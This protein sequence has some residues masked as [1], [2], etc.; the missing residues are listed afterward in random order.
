MAL[1]AAALC[2]LVL[3]PIG[4]LVVFAFTDRAR[5]FTLANFRTLFTDPAFV[6]PLLTT[7]TIATSVSL[8]CCLVAAPMGWIV[9]R[10]DMPLAAPSASW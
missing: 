7:L 3:L 4:W 8:I 9:A 10:T 1:L 2:L 6:D 5:N